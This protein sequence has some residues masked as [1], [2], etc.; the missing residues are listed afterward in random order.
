V[1]AHATAGNIAKADD[2]D[3]AKGNWDARVNFGAL[4]TR[5]RARLNWERLKGKMSRPL[6]AP[7]FMDVKDRGS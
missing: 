1:A 5:T 2:R 3:A 6:F 7:G 4:L